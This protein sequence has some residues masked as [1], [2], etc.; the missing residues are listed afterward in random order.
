[1]YHEM[2]KTD[3]DLE[4][5]PDDEIES[6]SCFKEAHTDNSSNDKKLSVSDEAASDH[7]IESYPIKQ[8]THTPHAEE[9]VATVDANKSIDAF[10]LVK[11]L[12]NQTKHVDAKK[13]NVDDDDQGTSFS[14]M[15]HEMTKT[16]FDLESMPDDEIESVSCFKEANSDN[17]S[18]D[19]KLSV[20]DEAAFDHVI[21][22]SSL[23]AK[24]NN[25]ESS[26]SQRV[27][28]K[29]SDSVPKIVTDALEGR[30]PKLLANTLKNIL[31]KL[32]KDS[33][34]KAMPKF[35]KRIKKHSRLKFPTLSSNL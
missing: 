11:E 15:Y 29:I 17:S 6:V 4:S 28:D 27:A 33:V 10:K 12:R 25:L 20:S 23:A 2:T 30:L 22:I 26:L 24:E 19:K 21:D 31:P 32:L 5:M 14:F 34:K 1:M 3:F 16:D 7:V 9:P 8:V 13:F 18:N 35:D